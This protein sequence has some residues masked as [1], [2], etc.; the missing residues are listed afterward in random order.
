MLNDQK[1]IL[2]NKILHYEN[3]ETELQQYFGCYS[4]LDRVNETAHQIVDQ[5]SL[6]LELKE[7]IYQHHQEDFER[8]GYSI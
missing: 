2:C 6:T 3:L 8:F 1:Q 7:I 4:P 5:H